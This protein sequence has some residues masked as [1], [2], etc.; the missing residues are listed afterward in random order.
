MEAFEQI[1]QRLLPLLADHQVVVMGAP[2]GFGKST[3]GPLAMLR[4]GYA[5]DGIIGVTQPRRPAAR[6]LAKR[7]AFLHGTPPGQTIGYQIG[8]EREMSRTLAVKYM[9]EGILLAELQS[10][11]LLR[12]YQVI[13]LDEVHERG[14]FQ[15]LLVALIIEVLTKRP[16]LKLVI[17]SA[18]ID[19]DRF[20]RHFGGAP[21]VTF[22]S[23]QFPVEI[24]Y[25]REDP[26]ELKE[27]LTLAIDRIIRILR[28]TEPGDILAF[29]PDQESIHKV[30]KAL[31]QEMRGVRILPLYGAQSPDEQE[32]VFER[33]AR[34]RVILATNIAE[35]SLTI[36]GVV[37]VVD[38]GL[39]KQMQY[40][41]ASMSALQVVEHS[42]AGCEQRAGRAGRTQPGICHRLYTQENF[43]ARDAFTSPEIQRMGLDQ[44]LLKLRCLG[45][46]ME[47]VLELKLM[48]PPAR[49]NWRH[50]QERLALLGALTRE[51][52]IT[53]DGRRM[54]AFQMEPIVGR[55]IL[56]A[57]THGC[58]ADIITVA[59]CLTATRPIFSR[60]RD[61]EDEADEAHREFT[62]EGSDPLTAL[63][64]WEA[65]DAQGADR[66]WARDTFLSSRALEEVDRL[67]QQLLKVLDR[68]GIRVEYGDPKDVRK[69][70]AAGLIVNIAHGHGGPEYECGDRSAYIHPGSV[71]W[72]SVS[73]FLVCQRVVE[74]SRVFMRG[75]H[76]VEK[77]W[78]AEL[79][80]EALCERE[81]S[82]D[83]SERDQP[84]LV[85]TLTWSGVQI[86][87]HSHKRI[88]ESAREFIADR[89]MDDLRMSHGFHPSHAQNRQVWL[90]IREQ[91]RMPGFYGL[92]GLDPSWQVVEE[93]MREAF[94]NVV[95]GVDTVSELFATNLV[96]KIGDFLATE[97]S[98]EIQRRVEEERRAQEERERQQVERRAEEAAERA[99]LAQ[100]VAQLDERLRSL[101]ID[102][103]R[104][105]DW[106]LREASY[107]RYA[108]SPSSYASVEEARQYVA[109]YAQAVRLLQS[110]MRPKIAMASAAREGVLAQCPACPMCESAWDAT[111]G[112]DGEHDR[113]QLVSLTTDPD[114][115]LL[116]RFR[117]NRDETIASLV[118]KTDG[119]VQI[120][121]SRALGEVWQGLS[122]KRIEYQPLVAILPPTLLESRTDILEWLEELKRAQAAHTAA[123]GQLQALKAEIAGGSVAILHVR[124]GSDGRPYALHEG[125]RYLADYGRD[126][127]VKPGRWY[128][129]LTPSTGLREHSMSLLREAEAYASRDELD[130]LKTTI[131]EAFAGIPPELVN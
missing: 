75:C 17:M 59:A 68:F 110:K 77:A 106:E 22:D 87:T 122:F 119:R 25:E 5:Q 49:E 109:R 56:T 18:T 63:K 64:A 24:R 69:A 94:L 39:I 23:R 54:D 126:W 84:T 85:E 70:I 36:D 3:L 91:L 42:R 99:V 90:I 57:Q 96:M 37:H 81:W 66:R 128:V 97:V 40:V 104:P 21:V 38:T 26:D 83:V 82:L 67:R 47:R 107:G 92:G 29:F 10:D 120:E 95:S 15:D 1:E 112:C 60:P 53:Q 20:S 51:G 44:V 8:Q 113:E 114:V 105:A 71:M 30:A 31:E 2:T 102:P 34:R 32:A 76:T 73:R 111:L 52:A 78:L 72:G 50:A 100:E 108:V 123:L 127:P 55:M 86:A 27:T 45:L 129:R 58:V 74:T 19:L 121:F 46:S 11:P 43:E 62:V 98:Q 131:R 41:D 116:G 48:D 89:L 35:T 93:K 118:L 7:V 28:G 130:E 101:G 65:W 33:D 88:P 13:V 80:P 6:N 14:V 103:E 4:A 124:L 12:R 115:S 117:T 61:K 16:D 125:K 79:I 9:T